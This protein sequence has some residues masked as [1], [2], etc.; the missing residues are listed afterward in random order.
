MNIML[1]EDA[2]KMID[3]HKN[4]LIDPVDMLNWT[5]LRVI[6]ANISDGGWSEAHD[7]AEVILSR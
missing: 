7:R 4:K 3:E 2:V 1:R 6:V 5:W